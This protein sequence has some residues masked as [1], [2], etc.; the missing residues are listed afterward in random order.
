[1]NLLL[2][3][4]LILASLIGPIDSTGTTLSRDIHYTQSFIA[5]AYHSQAMR[6]ST[7]APDTNNAD[8]SV[9]IAIDVSDTM[10]GVPLDEV[11][12]TALYLINS[13][14]ENT[15]I[16]LVTFANESEVIQAYTTDR[17]QLSDA[18][19][20]IQ[21]GGATALYDGV[22]ES[23]NLATTLDTASKIVILVSDSA[24]SGVQSVAGPYDGLQIAENNGVVILPVGIGKWTDTDYLQT[25]AD[26]TGG[27]VTSV[28]NVM[29]LSTAQQDVADLA[30]NIT[31]NQD[32]VIEQDRVVIPPLYTES[33]VEVEAPVVASTN[34]NGR[35]TAFIND[36]VEDSTDTTTDETVFDNFQNTTTAT[37]TTSTAVV[38]AIDVSDSMF[39]Y[40]LER[41]SELSIDFVKGIDPSIPV[42]IVTFANK[43]KTL[44]D[45]TTNRLNLEI[46]LS[47]LQTG[48]VTA[49]YDG[50][51]LAVDLATSADV[52]NPIVILLSDGGEYG[53][54]SDASR[55]QGLVQAGANNVTIHSI[56][57]G[58]WID[59][60][61]LTGLTDSTGGQ[62][63][64]TESLDDI[65][66]AYMALMEQFDNVENTSDVLGGAMSTITTDPIVELGTGEQP[67]IPAIADEIADLNLEAGSTTN[68]DIITPA[69]I[70]TDLTDPII[71]ETDDVVTQTDSNAVPNSSGTSFA[72]AVTQLESEIGI[73]NNIMPITIDIVDETKMLRADLT[74]NGF[75][76]DSFSE[77]PITYDLDLAGLD[78]G[79]YKMELR[80]QDINGEIRV[81]NTEFEISV[82]TSLPVLGG[83]EVDENGEEVENPV[84]DE[85]TAPRLVLIDGMSTQLNYNYSL[86][87]G[88]EH[89]SELEIVAGVDSVTDTG[90][91][92]GDILSRPL[93]YVPAPIREALTAQNPNLV[94]A[95]IIFMTVILMPPGLFTLYY[96][97]YT[98]NH[99][100]KLEESRSPSKFVEPQYSMTAIL[101]A[102]KE[103]SVIY[104]TIHSVNNIEYPQHMKE[105]L[106]MIR[107]EDDDGTIAEAQRAIDEIGDPNVR[108]IT[109]TEGPKN[110]PNGL[111]R[112][113]AASKMDVVCIFDAEDDP[114]HEIYN[115]VNTVMVNKNADVVQSGVQ[116]MNFESTWFSSF[117]VLE[118]FFWFK[119]GLHAFTREFNVTPLGGNTVFF[120]THWMKEIGGWDEQCLTEDADVGFRLTALG[121]NIEIVY[122][123][124]HATQEETPDTA[125]SFI[126]QRTRWV[127]GFYQM[128]FKGDWAKLPEFKQ[129]MV[130]LYILLNSLIQAVT[131]LF[132]PVGI[133]VA[134][135]QQVPVPLALLSYFPIYI[136]VI[137]CI[138][139][140]IGIREFTAAYKK[141]LPLGF[142]LKMILYYYPYQLMLALSAVRALYRMMIGQA[143]WEKTDHSNLHR[144]AQQ[145]SH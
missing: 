69:E 95:F 55:E 42:A 123:E 14:D 71:D 54:Q 96:M 10:Y 13:F 98:W 56:G 35:T 12:K 83:T 109:F 32:V 50:T 2:S 21:A 63:Y 45:F 41:A 38:I 122:D 9:V 17:E 19:I 59:E 6:M 70:S 58:N 76:L 80:L 90:E 130:A 108:I 73:T 94:A 22:Y 64:T 128:F 1:M 66:V 97:M 115:V 51:A 121:A 138:T 114:H 46:A 127:Q 82:V 33:V 107:D 31:P 91:T 84:I 57:I 119:S 62:L 140:L 48:G 144:V 79:I 86:A 126:K 39:G 137:Q 27:A 105:I 37:T 61:Y 44:Q 24:E 89:T 110:K 15:A 136:L 88:L 87:D 113:L 139:N 52:T 30:L 112:A 142:T 28:T 72:D 120:K 101:P 124:R 29:D 111:N 20:A 93:E 18:I 5:Q 103:E 131:L 85:S 106:I 141:R 65:N 11:K 81:V 34:N 16:A 102:R 23:V 92:I 53:E 132:L 49:L 25:L 43:A 4:I 47:N 60:A 116:L 68:R 129:R 26:A 145:G 3:T 104:Q 67:N 134:L 75:L 117:N 100:D 143:A 77:L 40:P 125:E 99:P 36:P 118:Y 7:T 74:L 133:Y 8:A 78:H 135:T